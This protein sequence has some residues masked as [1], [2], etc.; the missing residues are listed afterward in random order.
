MIWK[1]NLVLSP[2]LTNRSKK[3]KDVLGMYRPFFL[4]A[5]FDTL[6]CSI[7]KQLLRRQ[8]PNLVDNV[9]LTKISST[10]PCLHLIFFSS[11]VQCIRIGN[12]LKFLTVLNSCAA[13]TVPCNGY[14]SYFLS[15]GCDIQ[16][17][18]IA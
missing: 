8:N 17:R 11:E 15:R 1:F 5:R 13:T 18:E 9:R 4:D 14:Q 10:S 2:C 7:L 3:R 6:G 16:R 12:D